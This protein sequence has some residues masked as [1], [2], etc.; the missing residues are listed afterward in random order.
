MLSPRVVQHTEQDQSQHLGHSASG[1]AAAAAADS[2]VT[3]GTAS[4]GSAGSSTAAPAAA[5]ALAAVAASKAAVRELFALHLSGLQPAEESKWALKYLVPRDLQEPLVGVL[6]QLEAATSPAGATGRPDS[7]GGS[8][9]SSSSSIG[10]SGG[11]IDDGLVARLRKGVCDVQLSLTS[12]EEVFL[13]I[14]KQASI[15]V[16]QTGGCVGNQVSCALAK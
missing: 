7:S 12:L 6:Q 15:R 16:T 2:A 11:C 3:V 10:G 9:D 5:A 8:S 13:S 4:S 14:A 1:A